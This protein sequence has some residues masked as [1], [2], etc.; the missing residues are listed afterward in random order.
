MVDNVRGTCQRKNDA[1][2]CSQNMVLLLHFIYNL[3]LY[4]QGAR[5]EFLVLF[6]HIY[7]WS[8]HLTL[9]FRA[10]IP[11]PSIFGSVDVLPPRDTLIVVPC[12]YFASR[13][14][15]ISGVDVAS[16]PAPAD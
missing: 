5:K 11:V 3:L 9:V 12:R 7:P 4:L 8:I 1:A 16:T 15:L 2:M 10:P 13:S 14:Q 6:G